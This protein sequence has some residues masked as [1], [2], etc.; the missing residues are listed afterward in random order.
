MK[1]EIR[2]AQPVHQ[3]LDC[4]YATMR[5]RGVKHPLQEWRGVAPAEPSGLRGVRRKPQELS[6]PIGSIRGC[7]GGTNESGVNAA[8]TGSKDPA[9]CSP[10]VRYLFASAGF[11]R[12]FAGR[13]PIQTGREAYRTSRL[14]RPSSR[15]SPWPFPDRIGRQGGRPLRGGRLR[16]R[17]TRLR[18]R[19][20]RESPR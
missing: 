19:A 3:R 15:L 13:R 10:H 11:S 18:F 8:A 17:D 14:F 4:G 12:N 2:I 6:S 1:L 5:K 16:V 7:D 9:V 20:R